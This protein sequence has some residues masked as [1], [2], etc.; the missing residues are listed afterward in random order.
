MDVS[1]HLK[2]TW[3]LTLDVWP[4]YYTFL[5]L[6][7]NADLV[8]KSVPIGAVLTL[9]ERKPPA[10]SNFLHCFL[11]TSST[12]VLFRA[13]SITLEFGEEKV[14]F[15]VHAPPNPRQTLETQFYKLSGADRVKGEPASQIW[16]NVSSPQLTSVSCSAPFTHNMSWASIRR[17]VTMDMRLISRSHIAAWLVP[18]ILALLSTL[19][20]ALYFWKYKKNKVRLCHSWASSSCI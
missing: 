13:F 16:I 10:G 17:N 14:D 9:E 20:A 3:T 11:C 12:F 4:V 5:A 18:A 6:L 1:F 7:T 8:S 2:Y 15:F 19:A